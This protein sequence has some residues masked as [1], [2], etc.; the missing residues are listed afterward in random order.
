MSGGGG[1]SSSKAGGLNE[2]ARS[3]W[4]GRS[5]WLGGALPVKCAACGRARLGAVIVG[6]TVVSLTPFNALRVG[7]YEVGELRRRSALG[8]PHSYSVLPLLADSGLV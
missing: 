6:G 8:Q 5:S 7:T 4:M 2:G 1:S 3:R